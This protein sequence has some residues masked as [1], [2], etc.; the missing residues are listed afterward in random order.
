M[1]VKRTKRLG[2]E[3]DVGA[4]QMQLLWL[5]SKKP[6]HGY[7]LMKTLNAIKKTK[8]TQSTLYPALSALEKKGLVQSG[9]ASG[10]RGKKVYSLTGSGK[11]VM[12]QNCAEF[13]GIF[14][15]IIA[16]FYCPLCNC[17]R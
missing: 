5:L 3:S 2:R 15:G 12:K 10:A 8:V 9:K 1:S 7:E 4:L 17:K 11:R 16:D 6:A 13:V 14:K